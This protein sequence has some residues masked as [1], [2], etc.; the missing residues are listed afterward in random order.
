MKNI[1][2]IVVPAHYEFNSLLRGNDIAGTE[3]IFDVK[4]TKLPGGDFEVMGRESDLYDFTS[5]LCLNDVD[6]VD[7]IMATARH[8]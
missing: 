5:E 1:Y 6:A 4:I 7:D 8:S 3:S 2:V